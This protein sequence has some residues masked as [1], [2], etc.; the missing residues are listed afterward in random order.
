[1]KWSGNYVSR[2]DLLWKFLF[3]NILWFSLYFSTAASTVVL[4]FFAGYFERELKADQ[5]EVGTLDI[6]PEA[7]APREMIDLEVY[8][9]VLQITK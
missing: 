1:M 5:I 4:A 2:L 7:P 9:H 3:A 8:H 6:Y